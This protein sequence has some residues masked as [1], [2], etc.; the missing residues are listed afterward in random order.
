MNIFV[1]D[2][3]P[4]LANIDVNQKGN[5]MEL[6]HYAIARPWSHCKT[7]IIKKF[8]AFNMLDK[9]NHLVEMLDKYDRETPLVC[10]LYLSGNILSLAVIKESGINSGF[11][12][13]LLKFV[14]QYR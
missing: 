3:D 12:Q 14:N 11:D 4:V 13:P 2:R 5:L 8:K 7:K 6:H 1:L 9:V 10:K